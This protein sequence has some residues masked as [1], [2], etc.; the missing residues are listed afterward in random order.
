[1]N[2]PKINQIPL[3]QP[4]YVNGQLHQTWINFFEQIGRVADVNGV[5]SLQSFDDAIQKNAK[6]IEEMNTSLSQQMQNIK[7]EFNK[8]IQAVQNSIQNTNI[9]LSHLEQRVK[10]LEDDQNKKG[11]V[12]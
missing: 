5:Y 2:I 10:A 7:T 1:M 9:A 11:K 8:E 4:M 3:S 6:R 12:D